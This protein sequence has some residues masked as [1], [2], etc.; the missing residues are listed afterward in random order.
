[1]ASA[2]QAQ[3][4]VA[5]LGSTGSV[6]RQTL[7]VIA[8]HPERFR[9]VALAARHDT[10]LFREQIARHRPELVALQQPPG[11]GF[12]EGRAGRLDSYGILGM[13]ERA[14]SI[15]ARRPSSSMPGCTTLRECS[16]TRA[17]ASSTR[18]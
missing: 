18:R 12:P 3:I 16:P 14:A 4:G 8:E 10:P 1:M 17:R 15:G 2:D 5:V 9:V 7:E 11:D 13:R 6:G